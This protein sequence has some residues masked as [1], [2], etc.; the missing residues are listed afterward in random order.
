MP[1]DNPG[2][3]LPIERYAVLSDCR[4]AA[5]VSDDGSLDWLCLPRFDSASIF[6][7][8][9][10][11]DEH[12][13]WS[14]RP[15]DP[16]ARPS[17]R[18]DGDSF[19]LV[20]RWEA[21]DGVVDVYEFMPLHPER[22]GVVRRVVGVSGA[23]EM[24]SELRLRFDYARA[25]PWVRQ[26]GSHDMPVLRA[27]AGPD[28][29]V[30]RGPRLHPD[31]RAHRAVFAVAA[32]ETVDSVLTWGEAFR[33]AP[34]AFDVDDALDHARGWWSEWA[35][36]GGI[37]GAHRDLAVRSMLVLRALTHADTGGI[38]AAATTS[39]PEDF[40]GARNWDYRYVWLRDAALT[41]EAYIDHGYL[42][43]AHRWRRWLLRAVAGDPADVQ[44]LYG[45]AGERD[46]SE[47][48]LP[49]LPGYDGSRPVRVGN[50][51]V[52][53]YQ[54]DV[55]GEVLVALESARLAGLDETRFSWGLQRALVE[56]VAASIDR[57]DNGI[58]EI[59]GEPR[60]FTHSRVMV[61]AALDRG[62]RAVEEHGLEGPA[63]R[64][65]AARDAVRR[66]IEERAVDPATGAFRQHE[67]TD[68]VDASLLLIPTV[69]FCAA[70]DPRMRAT[71][72]RIEQ[73][74][75]TDGFVLRYRTQTGVDG[76]AG[77]EHPFLACSFWLVRQYAA[78]G[79]GDD[80]RELMTRLA[81]V[82]NDL[83]LMSEEYDPATGRHVG[84]T[85]QAL[86][87]L[88]LVAAADALAGRTGRAASRH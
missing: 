58:W 18:Y 71:V 81:A 65:R 56:Q 26:I 24:T 61:W 29:V 36:R 67:D 45:I 4:S 51:A 9:L 55:L 50:G 39:L 11:D 15:A 75:L 44:V 48:E 69:G 19:V 42:G 74:L 70:D 62:I 6:A 73:T 10:G 52:D 57:P 38:V 12:G 33:D 22:Q 25:T 37:D 80:A 41:L 34:D 49:Q 28:S 84:N 2:V 83:G 40:G 3:S 87:H 88:A 59:R 85:P 46:L 8:L 7:K 86:S 30:V 16:Q 32:G 60:M 21:S 5:L 66:R 68:E 31:G 20:T 27:L 1:C 82:P 43:A 78:M 79:R 17:R 76:L 77:T 23:V 72:A 54:A 63:D 64:W 14:L 47:R 53:Q 13:S 35:G